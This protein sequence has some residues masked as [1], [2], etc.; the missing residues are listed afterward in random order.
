MNLQD[1]P[2]AHCKEYYCNLLGKNVRMDEIYRLD[3][4]EIHLLIADTEV[5][6]EAGGINKLVA[7]AFNTIAR[8]AL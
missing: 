2:P 6:K 8:L 7:I 4:W 5:A 3:T 1:T